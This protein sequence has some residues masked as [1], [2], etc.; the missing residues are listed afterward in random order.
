MFVLDGLGLPIEPHNCPCGYEFV[1]IVNGVRHLRGF[2]TI[3]REGTTGTCPE[4]KETTFL[5]EPERKP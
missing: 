1:Q 4:C 2:I 3:N 5:G